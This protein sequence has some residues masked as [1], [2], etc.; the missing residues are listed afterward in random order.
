LV[1]V[2]G[3]ARTDSTHV[4]AAVTVLNRLENVFTTMQTAV[5]QVA[6]VA[7]EWLGSWMGAEWQKL[8]GTPLSMPKSAAARVKLGTQIG[9]DGWE[10][11]TRITDTDAPEGLGVLPAVQ[12]LRMVWLQQFYRHSD[13]AVSWRDKD[14]HGQPPASV[15]IDSPFDIEARRGVKGGMGWTGYKD[16]YTETYGDLDTPNMITD[17]ECT[18]GPVH[19]GAVLAGIHDRLAARDRLPGDHAL[20][21]AYA[22]AEAVIA[23]RDRHGV[24]LIVPL[25]LDHS[26]QARAGEGFDK[27]GFTIDWAAQRVTCPEGATSQHWG[28]CQTTAGPRIAVKFAARNCRPCPSQDKCVR[29]SRPRRGLTLHMQPEHE[30]MVANRRDQSSAEWKARYAGRAGV[31]GTMSQAVSHGARRTRYIGL[32]KKLLQANLIAAAINLVRVSA[33]LTGNPRAHTRTSPVRHL[34]LTPA[35]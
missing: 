5:E 23:A 1:A 15:R 21:S 34:S 30:L 18:A 24:T 14:K 4:L 17:A 11:W 16:H 7:P 35:A 8:Y 2:R 26:W 28:P 29:G 19:D 13:L 25:L 12:V 9:V 32:G 27:A 3:K 10:L 31:E 33:W 6:Q 20:D 22:D